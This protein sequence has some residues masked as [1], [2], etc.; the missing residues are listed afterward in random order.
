MRSFIATV[1]TCLRPAADSFAANSHQGA[2]M[3][4]IHLMASAASGFAFICASAA[5]SGVREDACGALME[6]RGAAVAVI[7]AKDKATKDDLNAKAQ[8][9]ISKL[10]AI[11][12]R[13]TGPDAK[14]AGDF[15]AIWDQFKATRQTEIIP[16]VYAGKADEA[17]KIANGV[18]AVRLTN[19]RSIMSCK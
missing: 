17:K 13:M 19:M 7:D 3:R 16:A 2:N 11:L 6:A 18:Q 10:D 15:K 14:T 8:A 12:A 5:W 9:A 4:K 1:G